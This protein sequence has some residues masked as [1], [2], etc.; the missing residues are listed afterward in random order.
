MRADCCASRDTSGMKS[1]G[2]FR[3]G[4]RGPEPEAELGGLERGS[5]GTEQGDWSDWGGFL[6]GAFPVYY[7]TTIWR[8]WD[9]WTIAVEKLLRRRR[10]IRDRLFHPRR[11][12]FPE[13]CPAYG[14]LETR[15]S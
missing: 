4:G 9:V 14:M 1:A 8:T 13:M 15:L 12:S 11:L 6:A 10:Y 2:V 7:C 3:L 5:V